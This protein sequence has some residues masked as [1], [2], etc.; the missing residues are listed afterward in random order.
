MNVRISQWVLALGVALATFVGPTASAAPVPVKVELSSLYCM[1]TYTADVKADDEAYFIVT[2]VAKG[3]EINKR[4]PESGAMPA[5]KKKPM[6][7]AKEP[8]TLWEGELGDGEFAVVTFT[9]F[10]GTGDEP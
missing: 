3:A 4:V 9:L 7:T 10:Q 5:N 2:G 6:V 1:K 8:M